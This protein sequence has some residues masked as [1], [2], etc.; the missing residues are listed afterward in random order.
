MLH[1]ILFLLLSSGGIVFAVLIIRV[2]KTIRLLNEKNQELRNALVEFQG[3]NKALQNVVDERTIEI[4]RQDKLLN[5]VNTVASTILTTPYSSF[6]E[7]ISQCMEVMAR[8]IEVDRMFIWQNHVRDGKLYCVQKY[9]WTAD[10]NST[11]SEYPLELCYDEV[12]P[13]WN[14]RFAEGKSI[15]GP[16]NTLPQP[17][18]DMLI[19]QRTR[20]VL[21]TPVF[22]QDEFW[23]FMGYEDCT[24]ERVFSD[25]EEGVLRS[26]GLIIVSALL[27]DTIRAA[28]I[29]AREAALSSAEAKNSFLANMSHELRTPINA[30]I[31][32]S[33][34]ARQTND[35][36]KIRNCLQ[37]IDAAS[38]QLL[39]IINDILDMSK[40]EAKKLELTHEPFSLADALGNIKSI[41]EVQ[42]AQKHQQLTFHSAP[43]VPKV[44]IGDELRFSQVLINLL[45]NAVKFTPQGGK[46]EMFLKKTRNIDDRFDEYE[47][48]VCD[49]GIGISEEQQSHLFDIF[50]QADS[51][52]SRR[53][54]GTGLGL[55]ISKRLLE[56]MGG[57][58]RVKS[59]SG[60]GSCFTAVF[61]LERGHAKALKNSGRKLSPSSYDFSGKTLLLTEDIE[62]NRDVVLA[63]LE[64]TNI[65][66]ECAE[67]GQVAVDMITANP[68]RY[69]LVY[70]DI[71]MPVMD[72][73]TATRHIRALEA[74]RAGNLKQIP[75]IAMT[76][77][78]FAEDVD[79]CLKAGINDHI[80]KPIDLQELLTKTAQY[81]G[82]T[83]TEVPQAD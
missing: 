8:N 34:I 45:S 65:T 54:G 47:I 71:Q 46:V 14:E 58:I 20:S 72:G 44:I 60:E 39:G 3:Y 61:Q 2:K 52:I 83:E 59:A 9:R 6:D 35:P 78:A 77:N 42:A 43:D 75:I 82:V 23:G 37:K 81:L 53:F 32:M 16:M 62:V 64:D 56:M 10:Q 29:K 30:V 73:Y 50:E 40:I 26:G 33:V 69:N 38:R 28:L 70:M 21:L 1:L 49:T 55:S 36:E 74:K 27:R 5:A 76:A 57:S 25:T 67:N 11:T 63:L 41:I 79:R 18:Q 19:P 22:L 51:S 12:L 31:G 80:A 48:T 68:E 17:V 4:V 66:I 15:N 7:L 13:G 24:H